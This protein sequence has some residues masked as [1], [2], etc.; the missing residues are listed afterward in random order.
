[1]G[2][3]NQEG[4]GSNTGLPSQYLCYFGQVASPVQALSFSICKMGLLGLSDNVQKYLA[5]DL[6]H[7]RL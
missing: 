5:V 6:V 1:M 2:F 4:L 7:N 3:E